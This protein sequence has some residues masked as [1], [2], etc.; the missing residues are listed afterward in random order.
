MV[1]FGDGVCDLSL[2]RWMF[3]VEKLSIYII[4]CKL[5]WWASNAIVQ[6]DL[7]EL[8]L[9]IHF[10]A[11]IRTF[12]EI[13]VI[14]QPVGKILCS[15]CYFHVSEALSCANQQFWTSFSLHSI[16]VESDFHCLKQ[17]LCSF[18]LIWSTATS[19]TRLSHIRATFRHVFIM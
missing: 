4:F 10:G 8:K 19:R 13:E 1:F 14:F 18:N 16:G 9:T 15:H 2:D 17:L 6:I 5:N 11:Q 12:D 7:I 3:F